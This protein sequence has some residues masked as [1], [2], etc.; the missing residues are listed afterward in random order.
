MSVEWSLWR[1]ADI[2]QPARHPKAEPAVRRLHGPRGH[3]PRA[4]DR[5][6]ALSIGAE[7]ANDLDVHDATALLRDFL[8]ALDQQRRETIVRALRNLANEIEFRSKRESAATTR[9]FDVASARRMMRAPPTSDR[10]H[11]ER[12][13]C[14][15][16]R[17]QSR[18][19]PRRASAG[20]A[21]YRRRPFPISIA[22]YSLA[23]KI[24]RKIVGVAPA[25][26]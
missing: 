10:H 24:A 7:M 6:V 12:L 5:F 9:S 20:R 16:R 19:R 15:D 17:N 14:S 3:C 21:R 18:L 1:K 2:E 26:R 23:E 4:R 8:R 22:R 11:D 25:R 13:E